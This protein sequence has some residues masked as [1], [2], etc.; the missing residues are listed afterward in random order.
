MAIDP[1]KYKRE[2]E[3]AVAI[4]E[5]ERHSLECLTKSTS[6]VTVDTIIFENY[7]NI[8]E[9]MIW[10]K[11]VHKEWLKANAGF[12]IKV[13]T[14]VVY[15]YMV[16]PYPRAVDNWVKRQSL[17]DFIILNLHVHLWHGVVCAVKFYD[18][19]QY[20]VKQITEEMNFF[21]IPAD[22]LFYDF[23]N[24]NRGDSI[25]KTVY[26]GDR[27][28]M[29]QKL[30]GKWVS[31]RGSA[32]IWLF[33]NEEHF[34]KTRLAGWH[35]SQLRQFFFELYRDINFCQA[36][37]R[38]RASA[39]D[40]IAPYSKGYNQ[41]ILNFQILC[42]ECNRRK[43]DL[44]VANPFVPKMHFPES[45]LTKELDTVLTQPPTWLG[46]IDRPAKHKNKLAKIIGII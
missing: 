45:L 38:N 44:E 21:V 42:D 32:L 29:Q 28:E 24:F 43:S 40:H 41:S 8:S 23:P 19:R 5:L 15:R 3:Q 20:C 12:S 4:S 7:D 6:L 36:C 34:E 22:S 37:R 18:P 17:I 46:N 30:I 13:G 33:Y 11:G 25:K 26:Q 31:G 27:Y 10:L 16:L 1:I 2:A 39:L 35:W 14:S 9:A